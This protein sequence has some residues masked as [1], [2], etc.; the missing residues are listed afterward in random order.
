MKIITK[1]GGSKIYLGIVVLNR[2]NQGITLKKSLESMKE[3]RIEPPVVIN[4]YNFPKSK[5]QMIRS[6]KFEN[7]SNQTPNIFQKT[8]RRK[9]H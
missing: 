2:K 6:I 1:K 9:N 8:L 7:M 5:I 4:E 3:I